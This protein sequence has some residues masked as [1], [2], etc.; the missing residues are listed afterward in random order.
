[1]LP[2]K[3]CVALK[4][5]EFQV[6]RDDALSVQ[7]SEAFACL[8]LSQE[9]LDRGDKSTF[10]VAWDNEL[11][12][13]RGHHGFDIP[14]IYGSNRKTGGHC[15]E[16]RH[17]H[18]LCIGGQSEHIEMTQHGFRRYAP[19]EHDAA[20]YAEYTYQLFKRSSFGTGASDH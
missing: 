13:C 17:R 16:Q 14:D 6:I 10:V 19:S 7:S 8:G 5:L 3:F 20:P 9:E 1:M 12:V 2:E 11:T 4:H 15:L 18:L